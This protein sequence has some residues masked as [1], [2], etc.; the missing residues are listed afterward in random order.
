MIQYLIRQKQIKEGIFM[1]YEVIIIGGGPAGLMSANIL[2][3][4]QI[5]FLLLEKNE[6]LGK[7][8]L[9]TGGRRSNVTNALPVSAFI[10]E[11]D[12]KHKKFLY[13]TL[14]S[15][16]P[17]QIISFFKEK[18]LTLKLEPPIKYFPETER[19]E[20]VLDALLRDINNNQIKLKQSVIDIKKEDE[21]FFI[22]TR[23]FIYQSKKV[24]I[25]T[26]SKSYPETGSN[27]DGLIFASHFEIPV[28]PFTPA[29]TSV[30]G[31]LNQIPF[32]KLKGAQLSNVVLYING[33]K[34]NF[35]DDLIFTHFGLSGPVIFK[36][37]HRIYTSLEKAQT[38][39]SFGLTNLN[40]QEL[41]RYFEDNK[42][43]V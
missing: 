28:N 23:D 41:E 20:S 11:L 39:I 17:T 16:G 27:G 21:I 12:F 43:E 40:Q 24:I 9:I 37:S 6:R 8:L 36:A 10:D 3:K 32:G 25:A 30:Y 26:G 15:F 5:N 42:K 19:S 33:K 2:S 18:G 22:K 34:T 14:T 38:Y 13:P 1:I 4:H 29:E 31:F 7:K 35:K